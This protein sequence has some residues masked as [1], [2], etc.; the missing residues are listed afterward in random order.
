MFCLRL[1]LLNYNKEIYALKVVAKKM[2]LFFC[3]SF[4]VYV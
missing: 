3:Y 1:K 2:F 4:T